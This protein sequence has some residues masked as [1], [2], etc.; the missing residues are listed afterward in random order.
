MRRYAERGRNWRHRG[1]RRGEE[2][3]FSLEMCEHKSNGD[4]DALKRKRGTHQRRAGN[5]ERNGEGRARKRGGG[6]GVSRG[7]CPAM[8][9]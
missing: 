3:S 4:G 9:E 7:C 2:D 5:G 8:G 1:E 6:G